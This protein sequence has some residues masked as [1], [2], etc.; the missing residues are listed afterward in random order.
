[1]TTTHKTTNSQTFKMSNGVE[2][3]VANCEGCGWYAEGKDG[4]VSEYYSSKKEAISR[5]KEIDT[6][7]KKGNW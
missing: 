7:I 6:E 2:Y 4:Y 1:M 3:F 5:V